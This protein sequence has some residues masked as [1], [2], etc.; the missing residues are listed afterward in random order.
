MSLINGDKAKNVEIILQ[1]LKM[2]FSVLANAILECDEKI[3]TL[4]IL[5]SLTNAM[6]DDSEVK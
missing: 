3:L 6:P 2:S 4:G 5:S 1:R